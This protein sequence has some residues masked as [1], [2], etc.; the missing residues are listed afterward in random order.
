MSQG[1]PTTWQPVRVTEEPET[2]TGTRA[3]SAYLVRPGPHGDGTGPGVLVLHSWWGLHDGVKAF[4]EAL[5]D[6]GFVVLA[7]NLLNGVIPE[8]S[9][10]AQLELET[11][12]PNKVAGLIVSSTI[13]LRSATVDPARPVAVVGFSM[14]A[15][16]ALW[17]ATRQPESIDRVVAYYGT[18]SMDFDQLR[19]RVLGHFPTDDSLIAADDLVEMEADLFE[20]GLEPEFWHYDGAQHF[21][22]EPAAV[23]AFDEAAAAVAW[24]RTLSFLT[25]E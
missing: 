7:P 12:D 4:C 13:A 25:A 1:L 21:F 19:A 8:T 16:W 20:R 9:A 6:A 22:A 3:G 5:C 23:D 15:S 11:S 2:H 24:E 18:Q 17:A 14:G 10:E